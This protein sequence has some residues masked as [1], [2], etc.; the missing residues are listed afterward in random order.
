MNLFVSKSDTFNVNI[1]C[2]LDEDQEVNATHVENEVPENNKSNLEMV[3][4]VFRKPNYQDSNNFLKVSQLQ[5]GRLE[6]A[7][8]DFT[9]LQ[10][11]VLKNLLTD[12]TIKDKDGKKMPLNSTN[13]NTLNPSVARAAFAGVLENIRF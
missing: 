10:E 13:I 12:W 2:Y 1:Y 8:L 5:G 4:F 9:V 6:S 7:G 11:T 3:T